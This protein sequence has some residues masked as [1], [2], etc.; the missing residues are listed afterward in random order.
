[1]VIG[2]P[3]SVPQPATIQRHEVVSLGHIT[4]LEPIAVAAATGNGAQA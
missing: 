2:V 3:P 1:V 4:L